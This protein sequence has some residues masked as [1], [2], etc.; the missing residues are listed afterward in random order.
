ML[1]Q[2]TT[3]AEG[4]RKLYGLAAGGAGIVFGLAVLVGAAVVVWGNWGT[5]LLRVQLY[6]LAGCLG[7]GSF[8]TIAVTIG[9]MVGGPV[10]K[11]KASVTEDGA[12]FDMEAP[13]SPPTVTTTTS[14]TPS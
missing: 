8:G 11:V 6:I 2:P 3:F 13:P 9:L 10:G 1:P 14:V 4:Q 12:S 5:D 7:A